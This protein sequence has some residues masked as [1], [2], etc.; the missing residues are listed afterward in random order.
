MT[1]DV[2]CALV[3]TVALAADATGV[4]SL[5][6]NRCSFPQVTSQKPTHCTA[7]DP[8]QGVFHRPSRVFP[9]ELTPK[10]R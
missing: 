6:T 10:E 1:L 5:N 9:C 2:S 8:A 7:G 4:M 3:L